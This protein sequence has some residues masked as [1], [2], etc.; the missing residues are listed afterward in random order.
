MDGAR[1]TAAATHSGASPPTGPRATRAGCAVT[2]PKS[3]AWLSWLE[4]S[5]HT[6]EVGGSSPPAPTAKEQFSCTPMTGLILSFAPAGEPRAR[7]AQ[8]GP[9]LVGCRSVNLA[10]G[11]G[12]RIDG[13]A[14]QRA[15]DS[16]VGRLDGSAG[17]DE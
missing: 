15:P 3:G 6:A 4:R 2:I 17:S 14:R 1:S 16:C 11:A 10:C 5:L 13:H 9:H 12:A 8:I 7:G